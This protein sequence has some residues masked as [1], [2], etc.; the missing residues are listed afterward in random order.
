MLP[1]TCCSLSCP[2][3]SQSCTRSKAQGEGGG[4]EDGGACEPEVSAGRQQEG[5][6]A[7]FA[8]CEVHGAADTAAA[9]H[10]SRPLVWYPLLALPTRQHQLMGPHLTWPCP[11]SPPAAAPAAACATPAAA[12]AASPQP[13]LRAAERYGGLSGCRLSTMRRIVLQEGFDAGRLHV[14]PAEHCAPVCRIQFIHKATHLA[15]RSRLSP[16]QPPPRCC[17]HR[18]WRHPPELPALHGITARTAAGQESAEQLKRAPALAASAR[19][20]YSFCRQIELGYKSPGLGSGEGEAVDGVGDGNGEGEDTRG[21]SG[22]EWLV[23]STAPSGSCSKKTGLAGT[24]EE[25][26]KR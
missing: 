26:G 21:Q 2:W 22:R 18:R 17:R 5:S 6:R 14:L 23:S 8:R 7:P 13:P 9:A 1:N 25:R 24:C 16:P 10:C 19:D 11:P 20:I 15:P 12:R 3:P 4:S